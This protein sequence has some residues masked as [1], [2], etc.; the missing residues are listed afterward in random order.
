MSTYGK[1]DSRNWSAFGQIEYAF[2][3]NWTVIAGG[4]W[5]QD[6]KELEMSRVFED[7][8]QGIPA[9]EIFN[10][11]NVAIPGVDTIDYGD[12]AARLQLNFRPMDGTLL[13]ASYNRGIKGGNW[14]LDPLGGVADENL[15]HGEEVLNAYEI[16]L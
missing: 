2:S 15:K 14:S 6:D 10:I 5:S 8:P 3:D 7:V 13:Y 1:V 16:G 12:Y 11:R 9:A 4:R